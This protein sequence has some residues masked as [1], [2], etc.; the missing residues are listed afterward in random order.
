[1]TPDQETKLFADINALIHMA[2]DVRSKQDALIRMVGA[3]RI[4][5]QLADRR[6]F[7][8]TARPT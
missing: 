4:W 3:L 6:G 8:L 7:A 1:M 2:E 5:P